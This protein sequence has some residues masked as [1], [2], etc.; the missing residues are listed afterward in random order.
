MVGLSKNGSG[1]ARLSS[2]ATPR[3]SNP[4]VMSSAT[5]LEER[6]TRDRRGQQD[7]VADQFGLLERGPRVH[8]AGADVSPEGAVGGETRQDA[9]AAGVVS[10]R[11]AQRGLEELRH[12]REGSA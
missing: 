3:S 7:R 10:L 9:R 5:L 8:K 11:L 1:C 6:H 4:G 2:I 12:L